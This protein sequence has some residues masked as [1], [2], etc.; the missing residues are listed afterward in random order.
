MFEGKSREL[1]AA[2]EDEEVKYYKRSVMVLDKHMTKHRP[3]HMFNVS[4]VRHFALKR[5]RKII[6]CY[7]VI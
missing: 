2:G 5:L 6:W 7:H 4:P 3:N 1:N